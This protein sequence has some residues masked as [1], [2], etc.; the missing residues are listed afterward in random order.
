M[1]SRSASKELSALLLELYDG[2]I[3]EA[4]KCR[5]LR[6]PKLD[7]SLFLRSIPAPTEPSHRPLHLLYIALSQ[8]PG[9]WPVFELITCHTQVLK[10]LPETAKNGSDNELDWLLRSTEELV[11]KSYGAFSDFLH[12][13]QRPALRHDKFSKFHHTPWPSQ[14]CRSSP[15]ACSRWLLKTNCCHCCP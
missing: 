11:K 3:S 5:Q 15:T 7:K 4:K 13:D 6:D 10:Y 9:E 12:R 1:G 14:L 8:L 2:P